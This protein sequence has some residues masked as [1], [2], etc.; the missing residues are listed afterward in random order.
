[1]LVNKKY[2]HNIQEKLAKF[3]VL[4]YLVL[5]KEKQNNKKKILINMVSKLF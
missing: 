5:D 2:H 4:F 1:M 3:K